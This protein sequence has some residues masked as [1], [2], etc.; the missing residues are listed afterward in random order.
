M[1]NE[2]KNLINKDLLS[3]YNTKVD[4]RED[5][6]ISSLPITNKAEFLKSYFE[7]NSDGKVYGVKFAYDANGVIQATS[8]VKY[9]ANNGL[10]VEPSTRTVIG[11]DD[12]RS[13][14]VFRSIDANV[15]YESDGELVVDYIHGEDGFSYYGK[16]DVV[17][18]F[19][20]VYERIYRISETV[21]NTTT[22][23][24]HIEWTDRPRSGFTLNTLCKNIDGKNRGWFC[25]SKFQN[26]MIDDVPYS[27]AGLYPWTN[28]PWTGPSYSRCITV[29]GA[30]SQ[31][32]SA[33]T[34]GQLGMIQRIFMMKY[35]H[36]NYQNKL[37][38][39]VS[40]YRNNMVI[41]APTTNKNF[42]ILNTA[43]ANFLYTDTRINIGTGTRSAA[44][45]ALISNTTVT[46][47]DSNII[48]FKDI[49]SGMTIADTNIAIVTQIPNIAVTK[50]TDT[51][52]DLVD[53]IVNQDEDIPVDYTN[54]GVS[55]AGSIKL[56]YDGT[57]YNLIIVDSNDQPI[58]ATSANGETGAVVYLS[59]TV[60][61]TTTNECET[62]IYNTGYSLEILGKD[63]TYING[64]FSNAG[65]QP[66]VMSGIELFTGIFEVIGNAVFNY[67]S[68]TSCKVWIQNDL[69]ALTATTNTIT[70]TYTNVGSFTHTTTGTNYKYAKDVHY[71]LVNNAFTLDLDGGSSTNGLCDATYY[72]GD[73]KSGF[74]EML[75][76][77]YLYVVGT[78]GPWSFDARY[79]LS[80]ARWHFGARGAFG[81][82][83]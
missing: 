67:Q 39:L 42:I 8:G 73:Q 15:H 82:S 7:S 80:L 71:D 11:R 46:G 75:A 31:Y 24:L 45:R 56:V 27:S 52:S 5:D 25:I 68:D 32:M 23:Y 76:F 4:K 6:K 34:I 63:G 26:V 78:A 22:N 77:G 81:A 40:Y 72:L 1:A 35:A 48:V 21:G 79:G 83:L 47:K 37:N 12:Y 20:P 61:V 50:T 16:V 55:M 14:N 74:Y 70:S 36:T 69:T 53:V 29:F 58:G 49:N 66:S 41:Q 43:D 2:F 3:Y 62:A 17:C 9:G 44:S 57:N 64:A 51:S 19:A 65:R 59:D 13:I 54:D 18:I 60:T 30:K 38:G 10:V 28:S 33:M